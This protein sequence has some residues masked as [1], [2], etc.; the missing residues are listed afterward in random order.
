MT[1]RTLLRISLEGPEVD[2]FP[3][4]DAVE[5]WA[6]VKSRRIFS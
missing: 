1:E 4:T 2:K 6:T 5:L 3:V